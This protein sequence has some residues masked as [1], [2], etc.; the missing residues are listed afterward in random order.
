MC[1]KSNISFEVTF[2]FYRYQVEGGGGS[3]NEWMMDGLMDR[4][5]DGRIFHGSCLKKK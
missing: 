2:R 3:M 4:W 5:M 1:H